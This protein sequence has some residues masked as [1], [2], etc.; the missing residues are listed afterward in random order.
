MTTTYYV[1]ILICVVQLS[2]VA[3]MAQS[4]TGIWTKEEMNPLP[5]S[6]GTDDKKVPNINCGTGCT[7]DLHYFEGKKVPGGDNILFISGG[8]GHIVRREKEK[9]GLEFLEDKYNVFY[10][11]IRGAGFSAIEKPNKFDTALRAELVVEDIEQIREQALGNDSSWKAIF[12]H[13][14]GTIIAQ[15]YANRRGQITPQNAKSRV[16]KLILSAPV[17][18]FKEIEDNRV[19]MLVGNLRSIFQDYRRQKSNQK[20]PPEQPPN[21]EDDPL[22]GTDNFCFIP[23]G[24]N[25]LLE[26]LLGKLEKDIL[27][28]LTHEFGSI[29]FVT[30]S[31]DQLKKQEGEF[32]RK[33]PYPKE[34]FLALQTLQFFGGSEPKPLVPREFAKEAKVNAAFLLGYYLA[35][36][37]EDLA[38][39][40]SVF[41]PITKGCQP[42]SPFLVGVSNETEDGEW[43][44]VFCRRFDSATEQLLKHEKKEL[45]SERANHVFGVNDG[46]NRWIFRLLQVNTSCITGQDII[47][48]ANG[49][50]D[51]HKFARTQAGRIGVDAEKP[52][53]PWNPGEHAH[54]VPTLILRGAADPVTAGCQADEVF[55]NGLKGERV[56]LEFPGVGHVMQPPTFKVDNHETHGEEAL[57]KLVDKFLTKSFQEFKLDEDVNQLQKN[58]HA[59]MH[60]G[61]GQGASTGCSN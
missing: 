61:T 50:S 15:L 39:E 7:F 29:A 27:L 35:L 54:N 56:L 9:R 10:F 46:L 37:K 48:F 24:S 4:P 51:K 23:S 5:A 8:P 36:D 3:A 19:K 26:K 53:C 16:E 42:D 49:P 43:K 32:E 52:I 11:D 13:S 59:T 6:E 22:R 55:K 38:D 33:Y 25:G 1:T 18:R 41:N 47:D 34:F 40:E 58:L 20:C 60:M 17:S 28:P 30:N 12:A 45:Q 31:Y 14:H 57:A 2:S 44:S 21:S